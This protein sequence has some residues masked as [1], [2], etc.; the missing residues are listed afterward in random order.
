MFWT[1]E[2][3]AGEYDVP[4]CK[5]GTP[6]SECVYTTTSLFKVRDSMRKCSSMSN[7]WCAANWNEG[8]DVELLRAGTHCHAPACLGTDLYTCPAGSSGCNATTGKLV[9]SNTPIYGVGEGSRFDEPG[10]LAVP[11][12][13]WGTPEEGLQPP[14]KL[15][16]DDLLYMV[17]KVNNTNYHYGVMGKYNTDYLFAFFIFL[18]YE[19]VRGHHD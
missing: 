10:Y 14:P 16:L 1:N 2:Q 18:F 12:C 4:Q 3:G 19:K 15:K 13:L 9:C 8:S 5:P 7:P 11:P 6:A 17:K